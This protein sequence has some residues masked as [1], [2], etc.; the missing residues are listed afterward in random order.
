[1]GRQCVRTPPPGHSQVA[2][3]SPIKTSTPHPPYGPVASRGRSVR[4]SVIYVDDKIN[5]NKKRCQQPQTMPNKTDHFKT[6]K[7][8]ISSHHNPCS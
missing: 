4:P 5:N 6:L 8:V 3:G 1:M 7:L 2:I